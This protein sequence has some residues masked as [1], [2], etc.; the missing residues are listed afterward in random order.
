M[1]HPRLAVIVAA[2]HMADSTSTIRN[3]IFRKDPNAV[4]DYNINWA[5]WLI[6]EDAISASSWFISDSALSSDL[7]SSSDLSI[8]SDS[9]TN[10]TTTVWLSGGTV[11]SEY[12][13]V[14]RITTANGR[15][16]DRHIQVLATQR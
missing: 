15:T 10:S 5:N 7:T 14:N 9:F 16:D 13:V 12:Y 4:L 2:V 6:D 3:N 8:D 11:P 1:S